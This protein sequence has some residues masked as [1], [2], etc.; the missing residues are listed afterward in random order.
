MGK[1][2]DIQLDVKLAQLTSYK[3]GGKADFYSIANSSDE[4]VA[5]VQY[6]KEKNIPYFIFGGGFNTVFSDKGFR[7]LV[8]HN[9]AKKI[10]VE[11]NMLMCDSGILLALVIVEAK[12]NGLGGVME[13]KGLP[14]TVGG[15]VY[16]NAGAHGV[17][18]SDLLYKALLL[19]KDGNVKEVENDYFEFSY[20]MSK[21]KQTKEIV[22]NVTLKLPKISETDE[23]DAGDFV[24]FRAN[25]QPKGF[26]AGSFFKNPSPDKSAGYLIDQAGLKGERVGGI[27]VSDLHGNWLI[28]DGTG[29][30]ADVVELAKKIKK[31]VMDRFDIELFPENIIIDEYGK[32]IDI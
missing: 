5:L 4:I 23:V 11:G 31:T 22:L 7:G 18:M 26:S 30:Q 6:A 27:M 3:I 16:G 9:K 28:N 10:E 17:S 25:K 8:I 15:A 29:T 20:R 2:P 13:L 1:L 24:E 32:S 19:D 12:K 21:L 14:G